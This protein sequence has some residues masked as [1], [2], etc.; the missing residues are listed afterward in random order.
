[1]KT[2]DPAPRR[3][4]PRR[5]D[6]DQIAR[7]VLDIGTE[8]VTMSKVATR[9]GVSLP[10][11]YHHVKNRDELLRLAAQRALVDAPPPRYR[12]EHW[13]AW[14]RTYA[15]F[16]R[17]ALAAEPALVEKFVSGHVADDGQMEYIAHA[18][19]ALH[20]QGLQHDQAISVWAAIT[21]L[22]MGSVTEAHRERIQADQGRPWLSRIFALT[23]R[24]GPSDH[25]ALRA[26]ARSGYDP[27]GDEA[28]DERI[29]LLLSGIA[30]Q[31][32]L[33]LT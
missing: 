2:A 9:L 23:A 4:R 3:G 25:P 17:S 14:L 18:L 20:D 5:I 31:Y 22:A 19:D 11:L 29:T 21:A 30:V 33:A 12:G 28:F 15:T 24:S 6:R 27:F 26:V 7:A 8:H 32:G 10:G 16:V 1:M 13:A